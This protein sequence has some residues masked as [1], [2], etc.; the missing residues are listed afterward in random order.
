MLG[1]GHLGD[2]RELRRLRLEARATREEAEAAVAEM[3]ASARTMADI[4]GDLGR[5]SVVLSIDLPGERQLHGVIVHVGSELVR[6]Q[7]A[8]GSRFDIAIAA[9]NGVRSTGESGGT[10]SVGT[11]HPASMVARLREL[12]NHEERVTLARY[13]G[14]ELIGQLVVAGLNH[15]QLQDNHAKMWFVPIAAVAWVGPP[16]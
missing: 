14:A 1:D 8:G 2:E 11:G 3:D 7:T 13:F 9:I 6:L 4:L 12:A 15:V 10:A 5:F 16:N